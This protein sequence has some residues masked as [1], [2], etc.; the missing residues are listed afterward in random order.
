ME[1]VHIFSTPVWISVLPDFNDHKESFLTS[2]RNF[3]EKNPQG[4]Q[5][6]NISGYCSPST[7]QKEKEL[8]PL[9]D[10]VCGM[11]MS[12]I[13][14]LNFVESNIF[15][16]GAWV[17]F[18]DSR[19]CMNSEHVHGDV[20]SGVFYLNAPPES[21]KFAITNPGLNRV[22]A[23]CNLIKEK[24]QFTGEMMRIEPEEGS[25]ILFPSYVPHSVETNNHDDERISISFNIAA[26][27]TAEFEQLMK[28]Q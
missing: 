18:N 22:W 8:V 5:K 1:I 24:N 10:Y 3:K 21:G 15:I 28:Q 7:L 2:V 20:F 26:L 6:S 19:Q 13:Q 4:E 17:N 12:A 16:T 23:G 27:P 14:D 25:I 9:F 11:A